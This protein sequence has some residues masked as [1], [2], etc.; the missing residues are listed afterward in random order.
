[1]ISKSNIPR[2]ISLVMCITLSPVLSQAK[3]EPQK[4]SER[5]T[6]FFYGFGLGI[7]QEIYPGYSSRTTPLPIIGYESEN[8]HVYEPFISYDFFKNNVVEISAQVAPRFQGYDES[9]SP[10]LA[11]MNDRDNT[12]EAGFG[13]QLSHNQWSAKGSF[14]SDL[15]G[16]SNGT[17]I[18]ARLGRGFRS[19]PFMYEPFFTVNYVSNDHVDYYYGVEADEVTASRPF[20]QGNNTL[21]KSFGIAIATP[22]FFGGMTRLSLSNTWYGSTITDSPLVD[23]DTALS[24]RLI[25]SKFF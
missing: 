3:S 11:G 8:L 1:M 16:R 4:P 2:F 22:I 9:D 14:L 15:L 25:F 6:G 17:D 23:E 10:R 7:G 13:V 12:L 5:P 21:N 24:T 20:Y 18:Q 19:G